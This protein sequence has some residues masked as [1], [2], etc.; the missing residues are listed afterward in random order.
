M[1]RT[2]YWILVKDP[3]DN[4]PF[5]IA[6]GDTEQDARNKAFECLGGLD[7]E[8]R[9]MRTRNLA[10]AS[11][12]LRGK[13]LDDTHSLH[14]ARRRIGHDRSLRRMIRRREQVSNDY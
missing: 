10:A 12:I 7:F 9:G 4:R 11:A 3:D 8:V 5:L 6:G 2:F 14:D 13:R 1:D